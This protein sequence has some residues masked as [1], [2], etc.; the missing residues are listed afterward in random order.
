MHVH[1]RCFV[2]VIAYAKSSNNE[3][4]RCKTGIFHVLASA[5]VV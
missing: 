2:P 1:R 5:G 4:Y 3:K